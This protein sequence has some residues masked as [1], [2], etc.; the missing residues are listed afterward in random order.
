[1]CSDR[2]SRTIFLTKVLCIYAIL[3]L[4]ADCWS[5]LSVSADKISRW[6]GMQL[7]G[8]GVLVCSHYAIHLTAKQ[9]ADTHS[10]HHDTEEG[11]VSQFR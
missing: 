2:V 7:T 3:F 4:H 9:L 8:N 1:M 11:N 10:P 6:P 5:M